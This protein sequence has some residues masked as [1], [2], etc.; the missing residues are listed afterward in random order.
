MTATTPYDPSLP[1]DDKLDLILRTRLDVLEQAVEE[2]YAIID[3]RNEQQQ[4]L[5][6]VEESLGPRGRL[7]RWEN[8]TRTAVEDAIHRL[9]LVLVG[10]MNAAPGDLD[11]DDEDED[12]EDRQ[13][14]K[15]AL[16]LLYRARPYLEQLVRDRNDV[17]DQLQELRRWS[18][19]GLENKELTEAAGEYD[20]L[21]KQIRESPN[22]WQRY[23]E[24]LRGRGQL[25][26]TRY[27]EL[28]GGMAIRG[29]AHE[30]HEMGDM[31]TLMKLL[32]RP[33]G[34]EV[35]TALPPRSLYVPL[36]T[37]H[38]PLGYADWG[39]WALP[40][41][42][43]TVGEF[44]LEHGTAFRTSVERRLRV[45]CA[46]IYA[47]YVVGP[48][49]VHAAV[50]L[51]LDP[52]DGDTSPDEPSEAYRAEILLQMLPRL[53]EAAREDLTEIRDA[54]AVPWQQA[55]RAAG[56]SA[57]PTEI[58]PDD[59]G[60]VEE[61]LT[62][63]QTRHRPL[64]YDT[65]WL[66]DARRNGERLTAG[67][68]ALDDMALHPRDLITALWLA[69]LDAPDRARL[70]HDNARRVSSRW[71]SSAARPYA[72]SRQSHQRLGQ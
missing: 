57:R 37:R 66:S 34:R 59:L 5:A 61:F 70:L 51:E 8:R 1:A 24:E 10:S 39:L 38:A 29:V 23:D 22:P 26:F 69:R 56:D 53:D 21:L 52:D 15:E 41:V 60:V 13:L 50:F 28:L 30:M 4:R 12:D 19:A 48:A 3:A 55:R 45:V 25:L 20:Q 44:L 2:T 16:S 42:G 62:E 40:L 14:Q 11:Q 68:D 31:Q 43:R 67:G 36:G 64:G 32:L 47:L 71:S 63:L 72:Q 65:K 54:I 49:Y 18:V 33:L 46:D 27:L 35:N 58:R 6:Q 9:S 7:S 17:H